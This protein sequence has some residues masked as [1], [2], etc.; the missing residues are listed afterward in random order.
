MNIRDEI[1]ALCTE[2]DCWLAEER[3][4]LAQR[5]AQGWSPVSKSDTDAGLIFKTINATPAAAAHHAA[6]SIETKADLTETDKKNLADWNAWIRGH[7]DIERQ[8]IREELERALV[9]IIVELRKERREEIEKA[10]AKRDAEIAHLRGQV[11]T[12]TRLYAGKSADVTE[13]P[14]GFL[15]RT[16]DAA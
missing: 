16:H 9:E 6:P 12:L 8:A 7:L 3:D 13:L 5:Q 10:V 15:R 14:K 1:R 2:A 11:E 4:W